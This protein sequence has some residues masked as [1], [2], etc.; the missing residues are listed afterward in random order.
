MRL[1]LIAIGLSSLVLPLSGSDA[2]IFGAD[3]RM[4]VATAPG[5]PFGPV[6]IVYGAGGEYATAFLVDDCHALTVQHVFGEHAPAKGR[7]AIVAFNV[8]GPP[9]SWATTRATAVAEGGIETNTASGIGARVNDWAL[10]RLSKCLGKTYGHVRLSARLPA[11]ADP[12]G[13]AGYPDD[14]QFSEGL[15]IDTGCHVRAQRSL[16]LLHDCAALPGNSGSPLFRIVEENGTPILAVFAMSEAAHSASDLGRNVIDAREN[17]PDRIWNVA[18]ALCANAP[19]V[20]AAGLQCGAWLPP[21]RSGEPSTAHPTG[22]SERLHS[23]AARAARV[24]AGH[25]DRA[26]RDRRIADPGFIPSEPGP[27]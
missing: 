24:G 12:I 19:L 7:G 14:R 23:N 10:L 22:E 17:Y 25:M 6:G 16:T 21:V 27:T 4:T 2:L 3:D 8:A 13:I 1:L 20:A 9:S 5:S 18:T 15:S 11:S 26:P